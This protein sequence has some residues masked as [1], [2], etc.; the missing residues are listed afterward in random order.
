MKCVNILKN[1]KVIQSFKTTEA[2]L[3]ST[4]E[5]AWDIA[6]G[7]WNGVDVLKIKID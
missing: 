1:G 6:G 7:M 2:N 4:L 5:V 3:Q